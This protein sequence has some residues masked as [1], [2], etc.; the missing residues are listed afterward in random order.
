M[1]LLLLTG[2]IKPHCKV[3]HNDVKLRKIEYE[4]NIEN[5]IQY[6]AFNKIVFAENSGYAF[7][8]E[9]FEKMAKE[10][11]KQFEYLDVS[12]SAEKGNISVGDAKIILDAI[13]TSKLIEGETEI[14]KASGRVWINNINSILK[15]HKGYNMFLYS[16]QYDSLQTWFFKARIDTLM[17]FFL[18]EDVLEEMKESCIEYVWK[19]CWAK[20][21]E[22]IKL[23]NFPVY[24]DVRGVNSS[25]NMHTSGAIKLL[26]KN[27]LLK[28]GYYTV[29]ARG[30]NCAVAER[31]YL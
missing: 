30:E 17:E 28:L 13:R 15:K 7:E 1:E 2:T 4:K 25:G 21:K 23:A 31:D 9:K 20:N 18:K 24:P 8:Y 12:S 16:K 27:L 11:G 19:D 29:K 3:E 14:W 26:I 6:S 10:A 22:K 5:Y